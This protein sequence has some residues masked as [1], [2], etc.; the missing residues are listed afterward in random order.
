MSE[1]EK[2]PAAIDDYSISAMNLRKAQQE[3]NQSVSDIAL[4]DADRPRVPENVFVEAYLPFFFY[5]PERNPYNVSIDHWVSL[6]GSVFREVDL[7][8][9]DGL[10]AY[11]VPPLCNRDIIHPIDREKNPDAPSI[12]QVIN[13][14]KKYDESSKIQAHNFM[15]ANLSRAVNGMM[16]PSKINSVGPRWMELFKH[17]GLDVSHITKEQTAATPSVPTGDFAGEAYDEWESD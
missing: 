8:G 9:P 10:I 16:D 1:M 3:I 11:T 17:Y 7:I 6:A 12:A 14:A 5:G 4:L 2:Q 15:I 13:L